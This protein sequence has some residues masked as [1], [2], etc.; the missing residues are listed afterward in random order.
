MLLNARAHNGII[1]ITVEL[2]QGYTPT[3]IEFKTQ[4]TSKS[5]TGGTSDNRLTERQRGVVARSGMLA[6]GEQSH[7]R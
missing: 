4:A 7:D 2:Q 5:I 3:F 1:V 6:E